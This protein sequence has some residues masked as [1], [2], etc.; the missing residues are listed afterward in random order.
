[1]IIIN[2]DDVFLKH[3]LPEKRLDPIWPER[4]NWLPKYPVYKAL[5]SP[6]F[7]G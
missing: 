4:T 7:W 6:L 2:K 5:R 3:S 1:M